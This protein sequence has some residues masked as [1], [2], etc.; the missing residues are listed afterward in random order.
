MKKN[1]SLILLIFIIVFAFAL[2]LYKIDNPIA[3]WHSFRQADTASVT[4]EYVKNGIDLLTPHYHDLS[5]IQSG[6]ENPKGYR[7]VEFPIINALTA[8][9]IKT[10]SLEKSEVVV[11]RL[12]SILFSVISLICIYYLGSRL[13][14]KTTG[15]AASFA[16]AILP[17]SIYYSR[18]ILPEPALLS[19]T[20]LSFVL[21][22]IFLKRNNF[23]YFIF[24]FTCFSL[25][26]L[27][28]PYAIFLSPVF[29]SFYLLDKKKNIKKTLLLFSLSIGLLPLFL[30]R[31]WITNFPEG[32]PASDWLYNQGNIRFKGAFF[33]WLFEVRL[34]TL[35][36]GIG[37][38]SLFILGL[39]KNSRDLFVYFVWLTCLFVYSAV[40]AGGNIQHDY[41]QII[42][43]PILCLLLGRGVDFLFSTSPE[44]FEKIRRGILLSIIIGFSLFVS[45][46]HLRGYFSVNHWEIVE[47]GK[48]IDELTPPNA[49]VIAPYNGD[50]AFLFQTNRTGW[51]I[52]FYIDEKIK[53]GATHYVSVNYDSEAR[54]LEQKYQTVFKNDRFIILN[55]LE[56]KLP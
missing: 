27:I 39:L 38:V 14:N 34:S 17:F 52:G 55:L 48:K 51:P 41:Y 15:L 53:F 7:M 42:Y 30:W 8:V 50:T 11:G 40:F 3:D 20:L 1:S 44:T 18:V 13:S 10:F 26:L 37:G 24:A 43:L 25:S 23:I 33:Y 9:I 22:H 32:I 36:L 49:K 46:Y 56:K 12:I 5:N 29:A 28:K 35:I 45:W 16:F 6:K 19:F 54:E 2:R 4:R 47:A 31:N 21:F